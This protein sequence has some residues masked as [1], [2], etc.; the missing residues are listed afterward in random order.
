MDWIKRDDAFKY[1]IEKIPEYNLDAKVLE[2]WAIK[3]KELEVV[4][5]KN[6]IG[7]KES[8][9]Y[10]WIHRLKTSIVT[11]GREDYKL[12]FVFAV[13]SYYNPITKSDFNRAKQRDVGEFLTNQTQGKLG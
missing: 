10:G 11:L 12:C 4:R 6:R 9:L 13:K 2:N 1:V 3:G 8:N 5:E 7:F